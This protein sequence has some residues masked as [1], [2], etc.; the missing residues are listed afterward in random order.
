[1]DRRAG[2]NKLL[3][4]ISHHI[5]PRRSHD[6][7]P[8][9]APP[10]VDSCPVIGELLPLPVASC[11]MT[12]DVPDGELV[13][14]EEEALVRHAVLKRRREFVTT[15]YCARQALKRLGVAPGPILRTKRGAP[16]WP[17]GIIGS[18]THCAGYRAAAVAK[19][20]DMLSLGI[21]AETNEALPEGVLE[22]TAVEAE[23]AH[24]EE[25]AGHRPD[26]CWDKLLFSAKESVFKAWYPLTGLELDFHGARISVDHATGTFTAKLLVRPPSVPGCVSLREFTGRWAASD[27]FLVTAVTVPAKP[28]TAFHGILPF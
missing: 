6:V 8:R 10:T 18:M 24:V 28:T 14:A 15:R 4:D 23:R 11:S 7:Q 1:M 19:V 9:T 5:S 17:P 20:Q 22:A 3:N 2:I 16:C 13:H 26:V 12:A 21:D 25:L 27:D